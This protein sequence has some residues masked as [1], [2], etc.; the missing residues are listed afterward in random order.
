LLGLE[1]SSQF[2]FFTDTILLQNQEVFTW[3]HQDTEA[4]IKATS[5][6]LV[7]KLGTKCSVPICI[8]TL[9]EVGIWQLF[10]AGFADTVKRRRK[11]KENFKFTP[12]LVKFT[13][14]L[15]T[16]LKEGKKKGKF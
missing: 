4:Y 12:F 2:S 8:P 14:F 3:G 7:R 1:G 6:L 10:V 15:Q 13:P 9:I 5:C 16:P 11:K